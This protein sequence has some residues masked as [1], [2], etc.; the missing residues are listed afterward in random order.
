VDTK[1]TLVVSSDPA[2][3]V[4]VLG[5]DGV[6]VVHTPDATL[7]CPKSRSED[8]KALVEELRRQGR[9]AVL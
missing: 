5:L 9:D 8:L 7:V 3:V 2:H 6:V 1:D 4:G